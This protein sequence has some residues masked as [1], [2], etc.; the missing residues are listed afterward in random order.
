MADTP[1]RRGPGRPRKVVPEPAKVEA[2]ADEP[3]VPSAPEEPAEKTP[4]HD[5]D[6]PRIGQGVHPLAT[7]IGFDD[8]AQ[9][10]CADGLVTK[11]I[12]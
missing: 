9:Y 7:H 2:P 1:V 3:A 4:R 6:D 10:E 11:R 8:G 12:D 5:S